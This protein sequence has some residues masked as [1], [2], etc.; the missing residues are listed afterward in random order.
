MAELLYRESVTPTVPVS[1]SVKGT[2]LIAL[3]IDGNFK[4]L[5]DNI[6]IL[7]A[8][9]NLTGVVTSIGNTTSIADAALSIAKTSGLQTELNNKAGLG[10]NSFTGAQI[11]TVS[12]LTSNAASI[13]INLAANNNFSHTTSENTTLAAPTNPVAGQSGIINITQGA[14]ARTLTYNPFWKFAGGTVPTLTATAGAVDTFAYYIGS[15]SFATCQLIKDI[16]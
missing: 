14:T 6:A 10:S 16:K 13:E 5:N 8:N 9:A 4:S 12:V 11:G 3:E 7:A 15:P 2:P 1:T